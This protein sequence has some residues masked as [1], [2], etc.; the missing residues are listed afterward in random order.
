[1]SIRPAYYCEG[2]EQPI[3]EHHKKQMLA[4]GEWRPATTSADPLTIGFHLSSLYSPVGWLS[5]ER[6]AREWEAS[7]TSDEAKRSFINT[8]LG[9]TWV[10]PARRLTGSGS[11]TG[12]KTIAV[13][14]PMDGLFLTAGA[15]VQKDRIEVSIW[16]WGRGLESWLVDHVVIDGGPDGQG[17]AG[18]CSQHHR[19]RVR[20]RHSG[21]GRPS[22]RRSSAS[23]RTSMRPSGGCL[24]SR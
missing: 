6:I 22:T 24:P 8:V 7:Q 23:F 10:R 1:M 5:W 13:A 9:K 21:D 19:R 3:A 11:T 15:D 12:V 16:A 4:A 14:R 18:G 17:R 2:C 20:R